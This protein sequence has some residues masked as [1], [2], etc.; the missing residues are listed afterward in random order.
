MPA[1]S[2]DDGGDGGGGEGASGGA[3][4]TGGAVGG[5]D[6]AV[7]RPD[8]AVGPEAD[9]MVGRPDMMMAGGAGGGEPD[10][11][12]DEP[13]AMAGRPDM[14]MVDPGP[15]P[16]TTLVASVVLTQTPGEAATIDVAFTEPVD[17]GNT[18]GCLVTEF[19]P[20]VSINQRG[21]DGGQVVV[22]G[23]NGGPYTFSP[24]GEV[25]FG[26]TYTADRAIPEDLFIEGTVIDIEGMGGPHFAPFSSQISAPGAVRVQAPPAFGYAQDNDESLDVRWSAGNGDTLLITLIPMGG[27]PFA[28]EPIAGQWAFCA[29]DDNGSYTVDAS[30][31]GQVVPAPSP[32]GSPMLVGLS[33]TRLVSGDVGD[34][35]E[36]SVSAIA[37]GGA[38][39]TIQ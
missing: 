37:N 24:Q 31:I 15:R 3:G 5:R 4:G 12:M 36:V 11:M 38:I 27:D 23:P 35:D 10:M 19:D 28:P 22:T 8:F 39:V 20:D 6:A 7:G 17:L 30:V 2:G 29:V 1:C 32:L 34:V 13:D 25:A 18:P 33:R 26:L 21:Y 16:E 14:E 9:A